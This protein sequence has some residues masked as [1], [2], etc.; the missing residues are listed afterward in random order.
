MG[1]V[2]ICACYLIL[3]L[4]QEK[5]IRHGVEI[6]VKRE[7]ERERERWVERESEWRGEER[8]GRICRA[9]AGAGEV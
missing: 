1:V 5:K 3:A 9:G 6:G 2:F 7:R 4:P 8:R